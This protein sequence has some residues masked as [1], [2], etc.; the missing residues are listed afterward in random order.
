MAPSGPESNRYGTQ[1]LIMGVIFLAAK[2]LA[3]LIGFFMGMQWG[4][5]MAGSGRSAEEIARLVAERMQNEGFFLFLVDW[6]GNI[7]GFIGFLFGLIGVNVRNARKGSAIAGL[8]IGSLAVLLVGG[9][10][11]VGCIRGCGG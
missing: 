6:F 10:M 8:I 7:V 9:M 1:S 11:L 4:G 3:F 5:E 2:A